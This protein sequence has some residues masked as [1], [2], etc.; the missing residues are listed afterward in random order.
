MC[1]FTNYG[2]ISNK[3]NPLPLLHENI[4]TVTDCSYYFYLFMCYQ[5]TRHILSH[6]YCRDSAFKSDFA[7]CEVEGI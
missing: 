5:C 7:Q 6:D 2:D 3:S 1:K 4:R